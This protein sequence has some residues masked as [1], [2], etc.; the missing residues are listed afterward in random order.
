MKIRIGADI[1][2][3]FTD[4]VL[5]SDDGSLFEVVKLPTT[6]DR[7]DDAVV[8]GVV[9]AVGAAGAERFGD[10]IHGT[11][12]FTNALIERKGAKTALIATRGFRDAVEIGREHRYDMYDLRMRR[13][14]P[15]APRHLR[16]EVTERMLAHGAVHTPLD[17][18]SLE[19]VIEILRREKV[20]AVAVCLLHAYADPTHERRVGELLRDRLP[21]I[22]VTLSSEL[23]P[24]IRE[25]ER[26]S[27]TLANV[28]VQRLAERY[29]GRLRTRLTEC[30]QDGELYVMQSNGGLCEVET[31][32]RFP[33]RLVESGPAAGALAAARYGKLLSIGDLLSFDMGG[34]TAKACL[35]IGGEP[36]ITPEFEV[37]RQYRLRKGSGLPVKVP[38]IDMIEIGTG[39][40]SI[41][42]LDALGRLRVGPDSAGAVPGP[43]CYGK[44]GTLPTVTDADLLL[45][46]LDAG[47]FLGGDMKLDLEAARRAIEQHIA[48]PRG[49]S[50]VEAA[51]AI[52]R[53]ADESMAS[54]ARI[55]AVERG[56]EIS[57]FPIFAYGGAGP[58]HAYGVAKILGVRR[59]VY[60]L[61]AGVVSSIGFLSAPMSFDLVRSMPSPLDATDWPQVMR[62][63]REMESETA[64]VLGRS[65][66]H[67]DIRHRRLADMRYR[68]QGYEIRV[69]IPDGELDESSVEAITQAFETTYT[70]LYGHTVPATPI[71]I[72]S[73]RVVSEG[74]RPRLPLPAMTAGDRPS[75]KG[76]R[77]IYLPDEGEMDEV[78][79]HDRYALEP[80]TTLHGPVV[81][82]ERESTVVLPGPATVQVDEHGNLLV[83]IPVG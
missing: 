43:V 46:Y 29:L 34:T 48:G 55:H 44:G 9:E 13:P 58:V 40:G 54:A 47:Y 80:G 16:F 78:E 57:N 79:V 15:L 19:L 76:R 20:E 14:A 22:A 41:A 38:V 52:H 18:A 81:V 35:I 17:E 49:T 33:I 62:I 64:A 2:G 70:A 69:A 60:P 39:G 68:K 21:G 73:W 82:E 61:A 24:E 26:G 67:G 1:G 51:Q 66:A 4:L 10:L 3:T 28:Y 42:R 75:L 6:P 30:G 74:P 63:L 65:V 37:D 83:D 56:R 50:T 27:T 5:A 31:A 7:P 32:S 77:R 72:V 11:T 71:E 23:V 8:M 12:L 59:I 25:Y 45:G 36:S 53:M